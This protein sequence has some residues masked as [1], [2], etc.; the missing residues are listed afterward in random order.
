MIPPSSSTIPADSPK[1]TEGTQLTE[2]GSPIASLT[3]LQSTF[4]TPHLEIIYVSDLTPISREE[5]PSSDY[6]FSKKRK[7]VVKKE[8]H[9]KEGTMVKKHRVLIDGQNL[10]EEDFSTEVA[11]SMGALA[12]TNL[13]SV[14]NMKTRLKQ[15]NQMI[16]QLQSQIRNSESSIREEI[17]KGL[18]QARAAD[19]QEIQ[20]LKSSLDEMYKKMQASQ[21][22][23]IQQEELARQ[24]QD[25]LN[26]IQNQV[27]DLKKFQAQALE[28]HMK[29]EAEQQRLISKVEVIQNYFQEVSQSFDNI[30]FK[31]KEAKAARATFQKAVVLSA[32]EE[33]S[34]TPR[35]SV[36]EQIRG[37]IMLKVWEANIAERKKMAKE[38][39]D[40]CEETFD[41]LDKGSLGIGK[42]NCPGLLGQ[43]NIVRHQLKLKENLNEIQIEISQLKEI[44]VTQIDRWLVKPNLNLQSVK[45]ADK[46]IEDRFPK[47]RG[48]FICSRQRIYQSLLD[49]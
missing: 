24:L 43:I 18:E 5:I 40:D 32:K 35:L 3:P 6:F 2:L 25:R 12:T 29:I 36:T 49:F 44:D 17:N 37:D 11:G 38:V 10:E 31:E 41:L 9:L 39:K 21:G 33:V 14:D 1:T 48:N 27:I 26:S 28:V 22:Q 4:G 42:D 7:V 15:K 16:A 20:L 47:F 45:F 34:K 30:V 8:M 23:V 13:F 46:G 19:K